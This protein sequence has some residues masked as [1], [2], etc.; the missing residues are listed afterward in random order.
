MDTSQ[1]S[2]QLMVILRIKESNLFDN[3]HFFALLDS[4]ACYE[5][6]AEADEFYTDEGIGSE[7]AIDK[8]AAEEQYNMSFLGGSGNVEE[9]EDQGIEVDQDADET[10]VGGGNSKRHIFDRN[11]R[12]PA[13]EFKQST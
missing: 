6:T 3:G 13:M 10:E 7:F 4:D 11:L 12:S 1:I 5:N 2:S 8:E 9:K